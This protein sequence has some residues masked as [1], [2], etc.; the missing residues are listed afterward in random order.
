MHFFWI[1]HKQES[2]SHIFHSDS[3]RRGAVPLK[4]SVINKDKYESEYYSPFRTPSYPRILYFTLLTGSPTSSPPPRAWS[5]LRLG[6]AMLFRNTRTRGGTVYLPGYSLY[7]KSVCVLICLITD[8]ISREGSVICHTTRCIYGMLTR[9]H[10]I[11]SVN[12][13]ISIYWKQ[14]GTVTRNHV[15]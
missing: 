2:T 5:E 7:A 9:V 3:L 13:K 11:H 8:L 14:H 12:W 1:I 15:V 4:R 6:L 10:G